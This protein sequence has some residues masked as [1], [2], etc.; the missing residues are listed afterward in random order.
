VRVPFLDLRA[1]SQELHRPLSEALTRVLDSGRYVLGAEVE[2]FEQ[3]W[4]RYVGVA[5][6]VGVASGLDA[7][8]LALVAMGIGA[9]DE[10]I[11]PSNTYI[12]TWLGVTHS[13]ATP[14]P[15]EPD[16]GTYN[17]DPSRIEAAVTPRTRAILPV[18][19][20]GQAADMDPVVDVAQTHGLRVLEDAAQAHGARYRGRRVGGLGDAAAW[21]FYPGKNLGALGDGGAVTTEDPDL[22]H[23]LRTLR[24]YGSQQ[25]YENVVVGWNSRLD[26]VQAAVLGVKLEA[27][28][29]W[30]LRR[31]IVAARYLEGLEGTDLVLPA[32]PQWTDP[33]WHLFVVR[34]PRRNALQRHL[35]DAGIGS[36]IHYPLPPHLQ[37]AYADLGLAEGTLPISEA[38]HR[39]VLSLPMGPHLTD[40]QVEIVIEGVRSFAGRPAR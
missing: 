25:K 28:D 22:A 19:L 18:H 37:A 10:V 1:A 39:E 12:G 13:G 8:H 7:L 15:V 5:H 36:L 26:E 4:A 24:N 17:L 32:V 29:E 20:Y 21:S 34:T 33:A 35:S 38:V 11:V 27:L 2:A 3:A 40:A 14:V 31:R 23:R 9:G 16:R 6:C 30:N